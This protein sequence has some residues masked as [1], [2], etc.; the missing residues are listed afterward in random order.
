M[1]LDDEVSIEEFLDHSVR[2]IY[3][4]DPVSGEMDE[5][6]KAVDSGKIFR[7]NFSY[8]GGTSVD[9]AFVLSNE[10]GLWLLITDNNRVEYASLAHAAVCARIE[11]PE[12]EEE[13]REE[14][15]FGML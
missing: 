13:D 8:R 6:R 5:F 7:F 12:E 10:H 3:S 4:L 9:P 2:L 15:D 1:Q 11:E 14:L